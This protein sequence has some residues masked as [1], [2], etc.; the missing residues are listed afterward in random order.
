MRNTGTE[1]QT[2]GISRGGTGITPA[3]TIR[4]IQR[5]GAILSPGIRSARLLANRILPDRLPPKRTDFRA[6]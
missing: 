6:A 4:R 5:S 1:C 2:S 3:E